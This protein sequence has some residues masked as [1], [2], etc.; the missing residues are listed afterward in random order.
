MSW[1]LPGVWVHESDLSLRYDMRFARC[2]RAWI[3]PEPEVWDEVCRV[4]ERMN[5]TWAWGMRW[6][7]PGVWVHESDLS[8]RYEMRFAGCVSAWIRPEPEVWD[9]V[10]QVC[11]CMNQTWAWGMRWGLPGVWAHESD[12][13]LRYE[14]RFA[15]CVSAWIRPEPEVW[16]EVCQVCECMNQTW[17]WGMRWGL[18]GVWAHES[19]LSLRYDMRFARC[20]SAWI[21]PEP[22]VWD[23]VCQ[24][25]E[26]MNQTWAWGMRLCTWVWYTGDSVV[27]CMYMK[28]FSSMQRGPMFEPLL[29]RHFIH[30]VR[31]LLA[32]SISI[33]SMEHSQ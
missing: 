20:V 18:P 32:T 27:T 28:H 7:L 12:L 14:M 19:D 10:C 30:F 29:G 1:G 31:G 21:R 22:E 33:Y 8:L 26:R 11:E 13:S 23:E 15:R 2:V 24:V 6:G 9:E 5:Q 3:R 17:A 4:C 16:H 25:C